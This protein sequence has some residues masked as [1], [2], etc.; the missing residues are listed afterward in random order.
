MWT[1]SKV[2]QE[3][4]T[5]QEEEEEVVTQSDDNVLLQE[6]TAGASGYIEDV[7]VIKNESENDITKRLK[8]LLKNPKNDP[9]PSVGSADAFRSK[10]KTKE[11]KKAMSSITLNDISD[12]KNLIKAGATII[13]ERMGIRQSVKSQQEP[14][15]KIPI[16]SDI[17]RLRKDSGL[18]VKGS[19]VQNHWV[20]PG[21]TQ[22]SILPRSIK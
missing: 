9:I 18:V 4:W 8:L 1:A 17:A 2:K 6:F 21:S 11:V 5:Q 10:Q 13:C 16:E 15:W 3:N 22:P 20:A 19:R 7:G 14:F 12:F